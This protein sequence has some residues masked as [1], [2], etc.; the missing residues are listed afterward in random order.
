MLAIMC[1]HPSCHAVPS[2]TAE[3]LCAAMWPACG[4]AGCG[5]QDVI[6]VFDA[7]LASGGPRRSKLASVAIGN[8]KTVKLTVRACV[9]ACVCAVRW[10]GCGLG[11]W[12]GCWVLLPCLF[13]PRLSLVGW[14]QPHGVPPI[15]S[16]SFSSFLF[17]PPP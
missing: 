8:M 1:C 11:R 6:D 15:P 14:A 7:M 10:V 16:F 12:A 13:A 4:A 9:R 17:S 2:R 5:A 3:A